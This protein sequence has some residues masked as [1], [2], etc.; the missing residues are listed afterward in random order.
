MENN[1]GKWVK[2]IIFSTSLAIL[3]VLFLTYTALA[4]GTITNLRAIATSTTI[5][6]TWT[7]STSS[8]NTVIRYSTSS[9]PA[10]AAAGSSAYANGNGTYTSLSSLTAGTNYYFSAFAYDGASYSAAKQLLVTTQP[11]VAE[12]TTIPYGQPSLPT[13]VWQAPDISGWSIAP[14]DTVFDWFADPTGV[15]GGLGM[16][17]N[18]L[19]MFIVG[20]LVTLISLGAYVKWRNFFAAWSVALVLSFFFVSIQAMQGMVIVAE[21]LVGAGVWAVEHNFQ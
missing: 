13:S 3:G 9:F 10:T 1:V 4:V 8:D 11:T 15:R 6:L 21:L 18:N 17:V 5:S 7:K 19:V 20:L 14:F 2:R 12:N 16:T